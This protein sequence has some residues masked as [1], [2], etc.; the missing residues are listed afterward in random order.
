MEFPTE[1]NHRPALA[2]RPKLNKPMQYSCLIDR[3]IYLTITCPG[4]SYIVHV[5]LQF[6]HKPKE[7]HMEPARHVL[8]YLKGNIEQGL[9]QRSNSD[10]E[11]I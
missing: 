7:E 3:L 11:V 10:C 2:N 4:L 5:L 9:L 8:R 6:M 1:E